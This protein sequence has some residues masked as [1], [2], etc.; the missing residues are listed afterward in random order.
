[1]GVRHAGFSYS[2]PTAAW[3]YAAIPTTKVLVPASYDGN[4]GTNKVFRK[5]V[6]VL[7]PSHHAYLTGVALSKFKSY[8]TPVGD[9]PLCIQSE[10]ILG[11]GKRWEWS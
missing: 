5:R 10:L 9:I 1:M 6:F 8:A 3:A 4:K 7:G 2:G 11:V